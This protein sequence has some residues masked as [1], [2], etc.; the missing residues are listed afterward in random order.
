VYQRACIIL[1]HKRV[2]T[3]GYV[4]RWLKQESKDSDPITDYGA[5][6]A[7]GIQDS[8]F[9]G[10]RVR[11]ATKKFRRLSQA[12]EGGY[13]TREGPPEGITQLEVLSEARKEACSETYINPRMN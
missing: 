1:F 8:A 12:C 9:F 13:G 6:S 2:I 5:T 11:A 10:L 3:V 7:R 4:A